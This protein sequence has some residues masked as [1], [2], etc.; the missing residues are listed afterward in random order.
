MAAKRKVKG[1]KKQTL[2]KKKLPV[3]KMD[4]KSFIFLGAILVLT[5][6]AFSPTLQNTFTNW[7]DEAYVVNNPL[8]TQINGENVVKMFDYRHPISSNYH[9]LTILSL[10]VN[11][12]W[13]KLDPAPYISTNI[14]LHLLNIILVF[15]FILL[16]TKYNQWVALIVALLFAIHPMHVESVAWISERK[17]V[18][19]GAFFIGAMIGYLKYLTS[20]KRHFLV[21][22]FGLFLLS[23]LSKSA[24]V[25][26]P[27]VL[28]TL[29]YYKGRKWQSKVFVEKI[30]FFIVAV[31]FGL[32]AIKTQSTTAISDL[33]R[34][35]AGH[36]ILFASYGLMM[37]VVK[38]VVP[39]NLS[40]FYSYPIAGNPL[41]VIFYIAPILVI[42]WAGIVYVF[43]RRQKELV[44]GL[45]FFVANLLLVLQLLPVGEAIMAD[46]YTYIAYIGLFFIIAK[47]M[48]YLVHQK[49]KKSANA[50]YVAILGL[51]I[52]VGIYTA[53]TYERTKI[54]KNTNTLWSDVIEK[55]PNVVFAYYNRG[56]Y[57]VSGGRTNYKKASQDFSKAIQLNPK[58]GSAYI[59]RGN[60]HYANQE[61]EKALSDFS[62]A[63]AFDPSNANA[64]VNRAAVYNRLQNYNKG[65]Q[66]LQK[67]IEL[68]PNSAN[69]Y[70]NKAVIHYSLQEYEEAIAA[71]D[72]YLAINPTFAKAYYNRA[73]AKQYLGRNKAAIKD[74]TQAIKLAPDKATYYMKRSSAYANLGETQKAAKDAERARQLGGGN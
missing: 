60:I 67:A 39:I 22:T 15:Y 43:A 33:E 48:D 40:S 64:Y 25:I 19:Y 32:I 71:F 74:F 45:L 38:L 20:G 11:Y 58:Y 55:H 9:P 2:A 49:W 51:L 61:N 36:R 7:D 26:L 73:L 1:A 62:K 37:Y 24:A 70:M 12:Q 68:N 50:K 72:K 44:F 69:A 23:L 63:I 14:A 47:G 53:L 18:L 29:D 28:L 42:G 13:A 66:D 5:A 10:A 52:V 3:K 17:D 21:L 46:R 35:S 57:N 30:P 31:I 34:W 59:G 16:L 54:W 56:L 65:L 4:W 41:P 8:I 27:V 6:F